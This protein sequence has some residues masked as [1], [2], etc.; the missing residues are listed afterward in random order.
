MDRANTYVAGS[1]HTENCHWYFN[2]LETDVEIKATAKNSVDEQ[3]INQ[4]MR[5]MNSDNSQKLA[6][7]YL[8]NSPLALNSQ[9]YIKENTNEISLS[10]DKLS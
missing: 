7:E 9:F 6:I 4:V 10:L 1:R 8:K 3:R 5:W 2:K